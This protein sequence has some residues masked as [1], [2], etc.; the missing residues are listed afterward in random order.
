MYSDVRWVWAK[1]R[2]EFSRH[3]FFFYT[4]AYLF[5]FEHCINIIMHGNDCTVNA[6]NVSLCIRK[7]KLSYRYLFT[8]VLCFRD[9]NKFHR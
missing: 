1:K 9:R 4:F 3:F 5:Q 2:H 6:P 8:T 7:T